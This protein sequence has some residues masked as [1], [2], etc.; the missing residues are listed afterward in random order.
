[1]SFTAE[2]RPFPE[3]YISSREL[4]RE[5]AENMGR[6][7]APGW[8]SLLLLA[9]AWHPGFEHQ[10]FFKFLLFSQFQIPNF[11]PLPG[12]HSYESREGTYLILSQNISSK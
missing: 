7:F 5:L 4:G 8:S 1:M 9:R 3:S 12:C 10:L 6:Q 2:E 11:C